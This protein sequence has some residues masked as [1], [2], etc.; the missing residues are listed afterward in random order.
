MGQWFEVQNVI[1]SFFF[2]KRNYELSGQML[3]TR[4]N[5]YQIYFKLNKKKLY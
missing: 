3:E 4:L 1:M 2:N 5:K